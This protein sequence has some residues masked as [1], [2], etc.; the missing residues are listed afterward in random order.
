MTTIKEMKELLEV[1]TQMGLKDAE[2]QQFVNNEQARLRDEREKDRAE[3]MAKQEREYQ[4]ELESMKEQN[5]EA[6]HKRKIEE[7]EID[8]RFQMMATQRSHKVLESTALHHTETQ[9]PVRGPKLPAFDEGKALDVFA[10]LPPDSALDF[11]EL[12]K[13]LMKRFD[14]TEDAFRKKF[15]S[16]KP[17]GSET[18]IQF[19]LDLKERIPPSIQDMARYADQYVEARATCSSAVTQRPI[20]DKKVSFGK[21]LSFPSSSEGTKT[22]GGI[23]CFNCDKYG[24]KQFDCPLRKSSAIKTNTQEK[25]DRPQK[26]QQGFNKNGRRFARKRTRLFSYTGCRGAVIRKSLVTSN[27]LTGKTHKCMLADGSVVD[28]DVAI[29]EVDTPY[30]TG[31]IEVSCFETPMFDLIL[32]NFD[33]VRKPDNPDIDSIKLLN[34]HL[35][36]RHA[37]NLRS[38]CLM[39]PLRVPE[40]LQDVSRDEMLLVSERRTIR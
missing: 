21:Q 24:H 10:R 26:P 17:D 27:Q 3:R 14:M 37:V 32:G 20:F 31:T 1:G 25:F 33:G 16:S 40:T 29:V 9:Q 2:L 35:L 7:M 13:A 39:K 4:L 8:H 23:K 36:L 18:F 28:A 15:R 5:A 30:F 19:Q 12:K 11:D 6:E 22:S 34:L 38:R